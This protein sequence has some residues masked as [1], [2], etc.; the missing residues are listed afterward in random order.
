ML[1]TH[2]GT[3]H[4][5]G[6]A[7]FWVMQNAGTATVILDGGSIDLANWL[8]VGRNNVA[9]NG[10]LILNNGLIQKSGDG[11]VVVGSL[12][13]TGTLIVNGGQLLNNAELWLGENPAAVAILRLNGG[14]L[15]ASD[16][17]GNNQ[18]GGF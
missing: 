17:R 16:I 6:G 12:G 7:E 9:A 8:V 1:I 15:Q 11:N 3:L 5:P 2:G 10:T 18:S 14:L 13:A 4:L